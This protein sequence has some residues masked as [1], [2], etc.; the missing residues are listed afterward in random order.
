MSRFKINYSLTF[1]EQVLLMLAADA[2]RFIQNHARFKSNW[3]IKS[4]K[5]LGFTVS[6]YRIQTDISSKNVIYVSRLSFLGLHSPLPWSFINDQRESD[7]DYHHDW[8]DLINKRFWELDF[9]AK[10]AQSDLRFLSLSRRNFDNIGG[11]IR[12]I[13]SKN[14]NINKLSVLDE[15]KQLVGDSTSSTTSPVPMRS[16]VRI[17]DRNLG[18]LSRG[19]TIG[20]RCALGNYTSMLNGYKMIITLSE[21]NK[22]R[23]NHDEFVQ[24]KHLLSLILMNALNSKRIV[25]MQNQ[26]II[27]LNGD[28]QDKILSGKSC[29]LGIF[30]HIGKSKMLEIKVTV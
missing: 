19:S 7:D 10:T 21:N 15:L 12:L 18:Y 8:L 28:L 25:P 3:V 30:S 5:T 1:S 29:T 24:S 9:L 13:N 22:F 16:M 14:K 4:D 17:S 6:D 11:V 23:E 2:E 27:R 20:Y 26:L